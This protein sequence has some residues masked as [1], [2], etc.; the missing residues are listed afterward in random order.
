MAMRVVQITFYSGLSDILRLGG[1]G[2]YA[3]YGEPKA[4][5]IALCTLFVAVHG[6]A[7]IFLGI[8]LSEFEII[9]S[10]FPVEITLVPCGSTGVPKLFPDHWIFGL[11]YDSLLFFLFVGMFIYKRFMMGMRGG[12]LL[13]VFVR[14][15]AWAFFTIFA[16]LLCIKGTISLEWLQAVFGICGSRLVLNLRAAGQERM[17]VVPEAFQMHNLSTSYPSPNSP[18]NT[19]QQHLTTFISEGVHKSLPYGYRP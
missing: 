16:I 2:L 14:D 15:G 17:T 6:A 13:E 11:V 12:R 4:L 9:Q 18:T 19:Q 8:V 10:P 5:L 7:F 1:T 3:F